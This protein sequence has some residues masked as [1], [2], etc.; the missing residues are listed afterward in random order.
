MKKETTTIQP[1]LTFTPEQYAILHK[2]V[3]I[4]LDQLSD[5]EC[6]AEVL[7]TVAWFS[8]T[9]ALYAGYENY[10]PQ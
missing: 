2:L 3:S 8:T 9:G 6:T 5:E 1:S 10:C 4:G 7:T